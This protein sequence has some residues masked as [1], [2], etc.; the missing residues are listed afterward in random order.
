MSRL[1][2]W[3]AAQINDFGDWMLL[4]ALVGLLL[5]VLRIWSGGL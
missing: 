2:R 1:T 3:T 5:A 4:G